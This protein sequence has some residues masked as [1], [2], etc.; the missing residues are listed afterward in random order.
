MLWLFP[1]RGVGV[2]TRKPDYTWCRASHHSLSLLL[3]R[4][5]VL[6]YECLPV[7][8]RVLMSLHLTSRECAGP[9]ITVHRMFDTDFAP[10][11]IVPTISILRTH[12][13]NICVRLVDHSCKRAPTYTRVLLL[14]AA[15]FSKQSS[16]PRQS[17]IDSCL[18]VK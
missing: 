18:H 11:A 14:F 17:Q 5:M 13:F 1:W 2:G 9:Q 12:T 10:E 3:P 6:S 7:L 16:T 8:L 4:R 15:P